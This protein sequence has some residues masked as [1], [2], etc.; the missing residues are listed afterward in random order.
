MEKAISKQIADTLADKFR[1]EN[2]YSS[3]EPINLY[4]LLRKLNT[5]VV[6]K[7]LSDKFHGISLKSKSGQAFILVNC[8]SPKGR[9]HFTIAHELYHLQFEEMPKPHVC[10]NMNGGKNISEKNADLFA[11][12]LLMPK[13]GVLSIIPQQELVNSDIK[14]STVVKIEQFYS[15][16]R[17]ALLTRLLYL[18]IINNDLFNELKSHNPSESARLFGEDTSLYKPANKNLI[19]S[20]YGLKAYNLFSQTRISEGHYNELINLIRNDED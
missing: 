17:L 10:S 15:V 13:N 12:S 20:D 8:N 3:N 7:P 14:I 16:S 2:G 11:A 18:N 1:F 4:S 5:L 6:F 19:I 9:Q